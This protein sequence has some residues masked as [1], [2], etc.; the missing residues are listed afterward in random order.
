VI[1]QGKE[2]L[3]KDAANLENINQQ[4]SEANDTITTLSAKGDFASEDYRSISKK[5]AE[6]ADLKEQVE[7][8]TELVKNYEEAK[9]LLVNED[10]REL[11]Q[12]EITQI[13]TDILSPIER[14]KELIVKPLKN[15]EKK[16]IIEFIPGV[17]GV[18]AS[19]FAED[20]YRVYLRHCNMKGYKIEQYSLEYDGEGGIKEASFLVDEV[21]AYRDLRFE[22]GVHRVQR[23]PS[24]ETAGRIHTSTASVVVLPKIDAKDIQIDDKDLR[25]DVYRSSGPGGQSVNTTD[26]AVRITHIPTGLT[27]S[28]QNGRSQHQNKEMAMTILMSKLKEIE[29][30]KKSKEE[31]EMREASILGGDRSSKIRTYNF[32]QSRVTDHRVNMSWFNIDQIMNGEI[33]VIVKY[34][35]RELRSRLE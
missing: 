35:S 32:Q 18:E 14:V 23:I 2:L 17:G 6:L 25:I 28:C 5:L 16:A 10:M 19:L 31:T 26:S 34:V 20:L 30:A 21:N 15:D 13:E 3:S 27:V 29:D 8:L 1:D 11:A 33:D 24:T 4:I 22:S 9:E 7:M 12:D